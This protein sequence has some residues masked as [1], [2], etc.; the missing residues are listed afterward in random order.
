MNQRP[1]PA[2]AAPWLLLIHQLPQNPPYFRVK[3]WRRLQAIGAVAVK[4]SVYALPASDETQEDFQ[5]LLRDIEAGGGEAVIC[6]AHLVDGLTDGDVRA[7]FDAARAADYE[8][9]LADLEAVSKDLPETAEALGPRGGELSAQASRLRKR[10]GQVAAIDF[11][12]AAGRQAAEAL[13]TR[14]ESR[15]QGGAQAHPANAPPAPGY[16]GRTWVTRRGVK[17]DRIA[18]AWLIRTFIDPDAAFKFVAPT[19]YVPEPGELRF[20][21]FEAEFTH[22]ADLCSF[23]AL[24]LQMGLNDAGLTAIGEIIHDLDLKDARFGREEAA[25]LAGMLEGLCRRS[26]DD[27]VR[28]ERASALLD[29]LL[30]YFRAKS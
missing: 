6:Q 1:D 4:A 8:T 27:L 30:A 23:E 18:C 26:D 10:L 21:M 15:L 14:I 9:L 25:G 16:R 7:L 24:L 20:D 5:W 3:I 19:G 17:V 11:F 28:I 22:Q 13:L 2:A 12:G 29:D